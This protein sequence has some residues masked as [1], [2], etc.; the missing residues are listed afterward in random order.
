MSAMKMTFRVAMELVF[1]TLGQLGA[2]NPTATLVETVTDPTGS[3]VMA[4]KV[5]VRN[6]GTNE[7]RKLETDQRGEFTVPNL[8]PGIYDV[9]IF[10][11]WLPH[12]A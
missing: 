8:P 4:A 3:A 6:S 2:Q 5:E 9:N 1:F 7:V 10:S 12:S 11:P